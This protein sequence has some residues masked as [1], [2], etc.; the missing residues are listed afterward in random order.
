MTAYEVRN[1]DDEPVASLI[2]DK[3]V[4]A[5]HDRATGQV[6]I[7]EVDS[8]GR[9]LA[10]GRVARVGFDPLADQGLTL[11]ALASTG[12]VAKRD[13]LTTV[14]EPDPSTV[15]MPDDETSSGE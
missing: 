13:A 15:L 10:K 6:W 8:L 7:A 4:K 12:K 1:A 11:V 3:P 14:G 5:Q 9:R 2:T